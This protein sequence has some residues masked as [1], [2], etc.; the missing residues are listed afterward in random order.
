MLSTSLDAV[1]EKHHITLDNPY[2]AL[3]RQWDSLLEV[4]AQ[5]KSR[6]IDLKGT[7]LVIEVKHPAW[8]SVI[9]MRKNQII[10]DIRGKY[11]GLNIKNFK[12]VMK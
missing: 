11:P 2:I 3:C 9:E 6:V 8:G 10:S 1:L 12:I 4:K 5:G 7:V